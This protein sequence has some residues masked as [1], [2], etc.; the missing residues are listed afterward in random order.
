V[1]EQEMYDNEEDGSLDKEGL[2]GLQGE[3]SDGNNAEAEFENQNHM[4]RDPSQNKRKEQLIEKKTKK[5]ND[6][7]YGIKYG[8]ENG[9]TYGTKDGMEAQSVDGTDYHSEDG[10]EDGE[11]ENDPELK[12]TSS[13]QVRSVPKNSGTDCSFI[14]T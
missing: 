7:E 1:N 3:E 13:A 2:K 5:E 10:K 6:K 14:L 12:A 11:I 9:N 8:T 4:G